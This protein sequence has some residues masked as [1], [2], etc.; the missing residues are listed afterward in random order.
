M[1]E[2]EAIQELKQMSEKELLLV[3]FDAV[4]L[5]CQVKGCKCHT[6]IRDYGL[7]PVYYVKRSDIKWWDIRKHFFLCAKHWKFYRRMIKIY[8]ENRLQDKIIDRDKYPIKN[9]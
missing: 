8:D 9:L 7:N 4:K 3:P 6:K 1:T 2:Q 5:L